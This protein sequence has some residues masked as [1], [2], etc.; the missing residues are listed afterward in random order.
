[1]PMASPDATTSFLKSLGQIA[2]I[3]GIAFG[4]FL[5][6]F[7]SI[8]GLR[9]LFP[10]LTQQDAYRL[11]RLMV[12]VCAIVVVLGIV[13]YGIG[14]YRQ[15]TT[16]TATPTPTPSRTSTPV[17]SPTLT[18]FANRT[19]F[20]HSTVSALPVNISVSDAQTFTILFWKNRAKL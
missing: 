7:Q 2:G 4:V 1:M 8:F 11:L 14:T 9:K 5:L 15:N 17:P 10:Q 12:V 16:A 13:V 18:P 20:A 6:I 19:F 3:G